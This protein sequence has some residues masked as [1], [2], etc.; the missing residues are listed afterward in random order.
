MKVSLNRLIKLRNKL[1]ALAQAEISIPTFSVRMSRTTEGVESEFKNAE[2]EALHAMTHFV[3]LNHFASELR[4]VIAKASHACGATEFVGRIAYLN[5]M[6][7]R[8]T[9]LKANTSLYSRAVSLQAAIEDYQYKIDIADK[10]DRPAAPA[11]YS[12]AIDAISDF[13]DDH[14]AAYKKELDAV[15][16]K[17]NALNHEHLVLLEKDMVDFLKEIDLI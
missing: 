8:F 14:I 13:I 5:Y 4:V 11:A 1:E 2:A 6:I 12:I 16:E 10:E 3:R 9:K 17:R 7:Q 15:E